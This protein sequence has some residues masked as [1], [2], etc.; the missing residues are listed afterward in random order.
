M[1]LAQNPTQA[2]VIM[3]L[4]ILCW[5]L[6]AGM[7]KLAG[8]WRYELFYF[9]VAFGI[10][11]ATIIFSL[12]LGNLGFDGFSVMDDLMHA[13]KRF[14]LMAFG[15]GV[16]FN[17][18][19]MLMM[20][21]VV[22]AGMSL[23]LPL[24]MG[25]GL[26]L[27]AGLGLILHSTANP[28]LLFGGSACLLIAI[29]TIAVAYTFRISA[30]QD[31]LVKEG[32]VKTTSSLPGYSKGM[33]VSSNAPSSTKGLVLAIVSGALMWIMLPLT[34]MARTP[35]YGLGP[36][37]LMAMFAFGMVAS[38]FMFNLFFVNLPVAGEPIELF[39]YLEGS[40]RTHLVGVAA[41]AVLTAGL[42]AMFVAHGGP[43]EAQLPASL[44]YALEQAAVLIGAVWGIVK[45][46]EFRDSEPRVRAM[47]WTFVLLFSVGL[48]LIGF[49]SN[50]ARA[51]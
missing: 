20:G 35:E 19:N 11:L 23:A 49:A 41:G 31:K 44:Y 29:V 14:W 22:V 21:A 34:D 33:I 8:K 7:Y 26:M 40:P 42:L 37:A 45:L 18:A 3:I 12:T 9:D 36:Y 48:V 17:L 28:L 5:G 46:K 39:A 13:G 25:V 50:F 15:A 16:A 24:G 38:T 2:L 27:G 51:A 47:L 30:R 1:I 10:A 4:G 6:W 32:K 43:P